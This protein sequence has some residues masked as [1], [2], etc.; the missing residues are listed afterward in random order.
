YKFS[1]IGIKVLPGIIFVSVALGSLCLGILTSIFKRKH[2]I[3]FFVTLGLIT[4]IAMIFIKTLLIFT[5]S[6]IFIGFSLGVTTP[7]GL[8]ILTEYLP[9]K[10]RGIFLCSVWSGYTFGQI[11]ILIIMLFIMPGLE[12]DKVQPTL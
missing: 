10:N 3:I 9:I 7:I 8:A 6:R 1:D 2:L 11:S 4:H 12:S 5:L